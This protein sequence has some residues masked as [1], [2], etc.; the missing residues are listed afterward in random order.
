MV[1]ERKLSSEPR[2]SVIIPAHNEE[3]YII[4]SLQSIV[5]QSYAGEIEII[6]VPNGCTDRTP[7]IAKRYTRNVF[8]IE[9]ANLSKARNLGALHASG[10]IFVFLDA[11]TQMTS[12]VAQEIA[13]CFKN[14]QGHIIGLCAVEPDVRDIRAHLLLSLKNLLHRLG[15]FY[16]GAGILFCNKKLFYLTGGFNEEFHI[17][18]HFEFIRRALRKKARKRFISSVVITSMRRHVRM[19]YLRVF[20]F[21]IGKMIRLILGLSLGGQRAF[22]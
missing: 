5:N 10:S 13:S 21:W 22:R 20:S 19:G 16:G 2:I 12:T 14:S 9:E 15:K 3:A 17:F 7:E 6:V 4:D 8:E 1:A 11:D 18:E